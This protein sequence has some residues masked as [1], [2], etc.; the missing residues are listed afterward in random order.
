M[1]A[2]KRRLTK[3]LVQL[4]NEPPSGMKISEEEASADMSV[5]HVMVQGAEKT[6]YE[7]ETFKLRFKFDSQYPF[8]SPEVC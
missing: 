4:V 6:L 5:W 1:D 8:T 2:A 3:E 7:N